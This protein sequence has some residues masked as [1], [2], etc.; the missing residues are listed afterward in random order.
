MR[1][2][3]QDPSKA[4]ALS[5]ASPAQLVL[6]IQHAHLIIPQLSNSATENSPR[7]LRPPSSPASKSCADTPKLSSS[8]ACHGNSSLA[9]QILT[10][11]ETDFAPFTTRR[12][13]K[14]PDCASAVLV[15]SEDPDASRILPGSKGHPCPL[16]LRALLQ[17]SHVLSTTRDDMLHD[18]VVARSDAESFPARSACFDTVTWLTAPVTDSRCQAEL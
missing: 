13:K 8:A 5:P 10:C 15:D 9:P 2:G 4:N 7:P 6:R 16:Q 17:S 3:L 18:T 1:V 12:V 14:G 11:C